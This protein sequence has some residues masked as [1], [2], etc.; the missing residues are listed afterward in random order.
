[1]HVGPTNSGKTH[2]ALQALAAAKSGV[3]AGPLRLLAHEIWD[4]LNK[5]QIVPAG[6]S[7]DPS[8]AADDDGG[9]DLLDGRV[10]TAPPILTKDHNERFARACNLITGEERRIVAEDALVSC[11]VEMLPFDRFVDVAVVDEIQMI[12]DMSRGSGW[13]AAVLGLCA[14]EIHLCGEETAVD[15]IKDLVQETGDELIVNRYQ[16]LTP[17]RVADES[18]DGDFKRIEKGDC[19]V[20]FSRTGIFALKDKIEAVTK[21][22]CAVAYGRLPPEIRSEQAALFNDPNSGFDVIVGSDAIGMGLNLKIKR[23][24]FES[25]R[26]WN[27]SRETELSTSQIKQIGGRAGRFGLHGDSSDGGVVTTLY[28]EDLPAVKIAM[29]SEIP[30]ISG[31]VLPINFDAYTTVQQAMP[32]YKPH[33]TKV[34]ET[35]S[36][37]SRTRRPYIHGDSKR[38]AAGIAELLD[39]TTDHFNMEDTMTW[40]LSPVHWRDAAARSVATRFL[41]DHQIRLRVNLKTALREEKLLQVLEQ[42]ISAMR[43]RRRVFETRKTMMALETLHKSVILYMWMSQRMPIVFPDI[44]EALEVKEGA[45]KAMEYV[46]QLM[47]RGTKAKDIVNTLADGPS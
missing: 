42:A 26:K 38:E 18:L 3:Y 22:R 20:S 40:F 19:V 41:K 37:F 17:L 29:D 7:L 2:Q 46:L 31:A 34:L 27:G 12:A 45:E 36:L 6:S 23:I 35:T 16:R 21:L 4:R 10:P 25:S 5:G 11:T 28:P 24:I 9:T 1:M 30:P 44:D 15:V 14:K 32:L 39:T 13:T 43:A 47:T 8:A 33:F